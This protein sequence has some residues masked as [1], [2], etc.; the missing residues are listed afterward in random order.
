M[1]LPMMQTTFA[2][3]AL[4][5]AII[6]SASAA[7]MRSTQLDSARILARGDIAENSRGLAAGA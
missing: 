4:V 7:P 5:V 2:L 6:T 1:P 3:G